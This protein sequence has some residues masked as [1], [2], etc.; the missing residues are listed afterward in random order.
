MMDCGIN[1]VASTSMPWLYDDM[2]NAEVQLP[3][4]CLEVLPGRARGAKGCSSKAGARIRSTAPPSRTSPAGSPA[5]RSRW[6]A[7]TPAGYPAISHADPIC[8]R[9]TPPPGSTSS[10]AGATCTIRWKT[11]RCPS[12]SKTP[13]AGCGRTSTS[14]TRW[15]SSTMQAFREWVKDKYGTIEAANTAWGTSLRSF[16]EIDPEK[17]QVHEP[18][19]PQVGVHRPASTRSTTGTRP[20]PTST[21]FRTELRVEELQGHAG[22][23]PQG[24]P[25]RDDPPADRGRQRARQRHRSR[26]TPTRTCG[27]STT[28]SA[29]AALIAEIMQK[30]G[31]V[32]LPL[33]LHDHALH[34]RASSGSSSRTAVEQG[35][36]PIYL[37]AV[38]Q[39]ARH[40]HQRQIRHATTRSTTTCPSRGRAR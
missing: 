18:V 25:G 15:A 26:K 40:R 37:A 12:A 35:I 27:T 1:V 38:R 16:D 20:L 6:I 5:R 33:G 28:A 10:T 23:R 36:I 19:R 3:G 2:H 39:H 32:Q 11:A 24:D 8:P 22:H 34:A 17:D 4:G 30:S 21:Q 9:P 29:G 14:A 31:V 7:S 13:A